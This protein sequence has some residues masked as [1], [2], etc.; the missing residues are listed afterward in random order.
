MILLGEFLVA[1]EAT[2]NESRRK[3]LRLAQA[4][5]FDEIGGTRLATV[6]SELCRPGL[7]QCGGVQATLGLEQQPGGLALAVGFAYSSKTG[8]PLVADGFFRSF[9]ANPGAPWAYTGLVPLPDH[10]FRPGAEF[11]EAQRDMLSQ[12]SRE[13]LLRDLG[14]KNAALEQEIAERKLAEEAL[15][16]SE[17]RTMAVLEGAPDALLMV[18]QQGRITYLNPQTERTFGYSAEE[19]Q[20]RSIDLLVP[21]GVRPTHSA[22]VQSFFA[23]PRERDFGAVNDL[24]AR[25]RDGRTI[26]VDV[27]L[28]PIATEQGIQVIV[29]VRDVTEQKKA[30]MQRDEA[31]EL[32]SGSIR[33][34]SRI[35]QAVLPAPEFLAELF[36]EHFVLWQPR[37]VVGGDI[38][39]SVPW[40]QGSLFVL[41]D[42]T[43]HGVPGAFMTLI[44]TGA[45]AKALRD[46]T[47]GDVAGLV[48]HTHQLVQTGLG[49]DTEGGT[50]DDGMELGACYIPAGGG[51]L[52]FCGARFSLFVLENGEVLEHKGDRR[53]IGYRGIPLN[54][55]FTAQDHA[56]KAGQRCFLTTDGLL[57]QIGGER[58]RSYGKKRFVDLLAELK[59]QPLDA[60]P[61]RILES[62]AAYQ[63][64]EKR[65]D[66]VS[67]AGFRVI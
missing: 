28:N 8:A 25:T 31:L 1:D 62:L 16:R 40:G 12:P 53:G 64:G 42:C 27:K 44:T 13:E 61:G 33:Y 65:R 58:R 57:D 20:G 30:Q 51:S 9:T 15:R 2:F 39:W 26:S 7:G 32:I 10:N 22:K 24:H 37:D 66:D 49:Q 29:S 23:A 59:D 45:L 54:F 4:L 55:P 19:L 56:L 41:G 43:G 63:G 46:V 50:S 52:R 5:G 60:H 6:Y 35:Q 48:S 3:V 14:R 38:Y 36:R 47:P 11:L 34:A 18:D 21:D 67:V 17:S